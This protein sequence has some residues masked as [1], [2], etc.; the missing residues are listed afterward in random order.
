MHSLSGSYERIPIGS[1]MASE[2]RGNERPEVPVREMATAPENKDYRSA[3]IEEARKL[4]PGTR[5]Y[6]AYIGSPKRTM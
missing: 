3:S 2:R 5:H 4:E 6:R 1:N